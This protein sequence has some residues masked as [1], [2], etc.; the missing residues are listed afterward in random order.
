[1][2]AEMKKPKSLWWFEPRWSFRPRVK[3]LFFEI[4]QLWMWVRIFVLA[5]LFTI[6]AA[7][8]VNRKFPDLD[9]NWVGFFIYS[10]GGLV[11][12]VAVFFVYFWFIPPIIRINQYG[13]HR[14]EGRH[15]F[16]RR[17]ADI[18]RIVVD[19]SAL[20]RPQLHV[21]ALNKKPFDCG[22]GA[23]LSADRLMAYLRET[24]PERF[25]EERK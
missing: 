24:F 20:D 11:F 12:S 5:L 10:F 15:V 21:E 18:Q 9:F 8:V 22:I 7:H 16:W 14:Q 13:V 25:V 1:M 19:R 6:L 17:R 4:F 2:S 23:K 3:A